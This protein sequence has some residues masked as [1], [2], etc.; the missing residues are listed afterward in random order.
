MARGEAVV[1]VRPF[2]VPWWYPVGGN[3]GGGLGQRGQAPYVDLGNGRYVFVALDNQL[4]EKPIKSVLSRRDLLDDGSFKLGSVPLLITFR[5][6]SDAR[7]VQEV[8]P[9]G[10]S[11]VFG[12][13]IPAS[14]AGCA[15]NE[16]EIDPRH[17]SN[18]VPLMREGLQVAPAKRFDSKTWKDM[19]RGDVR[20]LQWSALEASDF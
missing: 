15:R 12:A 8:P 5:N 19:E 20:R 6:I 2:K 9:D 10:F 11:G 1:E 18:E 4:N 7:T 13:G 16:R 14:P 17:P 3:R